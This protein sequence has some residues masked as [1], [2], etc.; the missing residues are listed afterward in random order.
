MHRA[1]H[2]DRSRDRSRDGRGRMS[3][4]RR[5]FC[6]MLLS[7][8]FLLHPLIPSCCC[9]CVRQGTAPFSS[10]RPTHPSFCRPVHGS[11]LAGGPICPEMCTDP[12]LWVSHEHGR[13]LLVRRHKGYSSVQAEVTACGTTAGCW[14]LRPSGET[15]LFTYWRPEGDEGDL[16][17]IRT[18]VDIHQVNLRNIY[19]VVHRC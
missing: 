17:I 1:Q 15:Y 9:P 8:C 16:N 12:D 4:F 10:A 7:P 19:V 5:A 2:R 13:V 18:L 11:W 14:S 3:A 6:L